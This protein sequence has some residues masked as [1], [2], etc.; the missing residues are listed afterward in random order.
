MK[1]NNSILIITFVLF[2]IGCASYN[3]KIE[4]KFIEGIWVFESEINNLYIKDT[5]FDYKHQRP[6][7][8][9]FKKNNSL[10]IKKY[11]IKETTFCFD[12]YK[13]RVLF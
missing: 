1:K 11:G 7:I 6:I 5:T 9:D 2:L 12:P 10:T 4:K 3:N 8:F 13:T